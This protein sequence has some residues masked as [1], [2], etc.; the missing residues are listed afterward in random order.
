MDTKLFVFLHITTNAISAAMSRQPMWKPSASS[1]DSCNLTRFARTIGFEPPDYGALH[2]WSVTNRAEFWKRAWDFLDVVGDLGSSIVQNENDFLASR[3]FSDSRLNYAENLTRRD[4][5]ATAIVGILETGDIHRLSFSELRRKTA[6]FAAELRDR[7]IGKGDRVAAFLPNVPE[8]I[9][10][11]L[12][13]T[14]IGAVWSSCSPDFGFQGALDRFGQIAPKLLI[15]ADGYW[16]NERVFNVEETAN[17]LKQHIE[18]IDDVF[19]LKLLDDTQD[20]FDA[21]W[22]R[23]ETEQVFERF[24]F[25]HPLY[26]MYSSG[27]TGKPKC[28]VHG[29]GGTLLQHLKEHQLHVDLGSSSRVFFYTT[30]GW[31]MWNWLVS[32]LASESTLVLYD[33]SPFKPD[34]LRLLRMAE[35]ESI[36]EF[37]AG[38]KYYSTQQKSGVSLKGTQGLNSVRTIL[39]TGSPLLPDTF[40]YIY[41]HLKSDVHLASISGGTDIMSCFVL[42]NPW[43]PVY[44]GEIQGPGLAMDMDVYDEDGHSILGQKGELVCKESFPSKPIGFWE[45]PGDDRYRSAYFSM[46]SNVWAHRDFAEVIPLTGGYV[47]HGRSDSVLNPGGVRIG[48][49]EIYRQVESMDEIEEAL[50]IGQTWEDDTRIVLFVVV[51]KGSNFTDDLVHRIKLRIRQHASPKHVPAIVLEV[52]DLPRTRSGKIAEIA[53]RDIVHG[54]K[55]G[56]HFGTRESRNS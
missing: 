22:K 56:Q 3:W 36:T 50:C 8:T 35:D 1:I 51:T 21:I 24:P 48:T 28:I 49:A 9:V 11:M 43:S 10:A 34:P 41:S 53:V 40:D 7:G 18:S 4:D 23:S 54:R 5:D 27:T 2:Q 46:Y 31:M 38:A 15:S 55:C 37:G 16:Y 13:T 47:I 29:A 52:S 44:R 20:D 42:G 6:Q 19:W 33:G 25:D 30:C 14:S 12:G 17:Q 45:D 32:A 39:S 26:I